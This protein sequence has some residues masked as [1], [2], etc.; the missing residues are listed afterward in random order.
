MTEPDP[1]E[2]DARRLLGETLDALG[3]SAAYGAGTITDAE[4][5]KALLDLMERRRAAFGDDA[6]TL[7]DEIAPDE[8]AEFGVKDAI[9]SWRDRLAS[10]IRK[11]L[12]AAAL[13]FGG[14][15]LHADDLAT[16]D[17]AQAVQVG[18]LDRFAAALRSG[19]TKPD[20]SLASRAG[21]YASAAW[22]AAQAVLVGKAKRD[23]A[24][25]GTWHLDDAALHCL[26]C[27]EQAAR[28]VQPLDS[29]PPIGS[30]SCS[31][32][33]RCHLEIQQ[34]T[35]GQTVPFSVD[36]ATWDVVEPSRSWAVTF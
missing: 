27:P 22:G 24:T 30:L 6:G 25:H 28:G 20:G 13:L 23:G 33:C 17:A 29:F 11:T 3:L 2:A 12:L 9:G 10:G 31:A 34:P 14:P 8:P 26:D 1:D 16:V 7:R 35:A 36:L 5:R 21:S 19:E 18:Y 32:G 15:E 4:R